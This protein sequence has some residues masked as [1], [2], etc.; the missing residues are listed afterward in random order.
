MYSEV[1]KNSLKLLASSFLA[2][3]LRTFFT[4]RALKGK[5]GTQRALQGHSKST[6]RVTE[7]SG[8]LALEGHSS[9]PEIEALYLVDSIVN[10]SGYYH[11]MFKLKK[12]Y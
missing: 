10:T 4:R 3:M 6:R 5:L 7:H 12:N 2:V 8:T 11:E 1:F 9:I